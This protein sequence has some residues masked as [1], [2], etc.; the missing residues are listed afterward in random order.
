[1]LGVYDQP[2]IVRR[3]VDLLRSELA[4]IKAQTKHFTATAAAAAAGAVSRTVVKHVAEIHLLQQVLASTA[5]TAVSIVRR[6]Q[7]EEV[8]TQPPHLSTTDVTKEST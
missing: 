1:M 5:T 7:S 2:L 4:H 8:V 6:L 3:N